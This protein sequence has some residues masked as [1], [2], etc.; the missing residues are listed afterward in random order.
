MAALIRV[1]APVAA[2]AVILLTCALLFNALFADGTSPAEI[3][4]AFAKVENVCIATCRAGATEP[5][6]QVWASQTLK[7]KL[8]RSGSGSQAQFTLWDV[9]NKVK[10]MKF[11]ASEPVATQ[12]ITEQMLVELG[13]SVIPSAGLL[14]FSGAPEDAKWSAVDDPKTAAP[15]PGAEV[16]DLT[17]AASGSPSEAVV[18]KRCRLFADRRSHLP[19]RA[20]WYAR[21]GAEDD[22]RLETFVIFAYPSAGEIEDLVESTFGSRRPDQPEYIP[23]PGMDR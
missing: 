15:V 20:E 5:F 21:S 17:W 2:A 10:M 22:Y 18:Y 3:R 11:L 23:T 16:Y 6:Q 1:A 7:V 9:R 13:R 4:K 8:L 12:P 19:K 14:A